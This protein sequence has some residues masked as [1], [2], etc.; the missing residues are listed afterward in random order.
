MGNLW[1]LMNLGWVKDGESIERE[2]FRPNFRS[3]TGR[4]EW[5]MIGPGHRGTGVLCHAKMLI[6]PGNQ[7]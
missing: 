5:Q 7:F 3:Q 2:K 4:G 6:I 1:K